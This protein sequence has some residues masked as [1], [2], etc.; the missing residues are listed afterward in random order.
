[1]SSPSSTLVPQERDRVGAASACTCQCNGT[2]RL[3]LL[4]LGAIA[5]GGDDL[6][7]A[8]VGRDLGDLVLNL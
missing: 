2:H 6:G 3:A 7:E 8:A 4:G 1:M 5:R